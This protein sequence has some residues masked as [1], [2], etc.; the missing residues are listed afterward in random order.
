MRRFVVCNC[1]YF[2][3]NNKWHGIAEHS[4]T[5]HYCDLEFQFR[6][7]TILHIWIAA[8]SLRFPLLPSKP[9]RH[10]NVKEYVRSSGTYANE[11]ER[12]HTHPLIIF[13]PNGFLL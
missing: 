7:V 9:L 1:L 5:K 4:T 10:E 8:A 13:E 11:S 12:Q 2:C 6:I 3:S